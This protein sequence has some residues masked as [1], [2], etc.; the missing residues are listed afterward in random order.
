MLGTTA[1]L[2]WFATVGWT[3]AAAS[4]VWT[5][6]L[7]LAGGCAAYAASSAL[8]ASNVA[9]RTTGYTWLTYGVLAVATV[10]VAASAFVS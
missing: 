3:L 7:L 8:I 10:L 6:D 2:M 4:I 9:G 5:G 1:R